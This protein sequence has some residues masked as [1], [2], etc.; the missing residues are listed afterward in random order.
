MRRGTTDF[1][2][3]ER[4][5]HRRRA[6]QPCRRRGAFDQRRGPSCACR[7]PFGGRRGPSCRKPPSVTRTCSC[8]CQFGNRRKFGLY[9]RGNRCQMVLEQR[10]PR[11]FFR[12]PLYAR[13][14]WIV[15][16]TARHGDDDAM[17]GASLTV[18]RGQPWEPG[19]RPQRRPIWPQVV[20]GCT[21]PADTSAHVIEPVPAGP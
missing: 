16:S 15:R 13:R 17:V 21:E 14:T 1:H 7:G 11:S 5:G 2:H 4:V 18:V 20:G 19:S 6:R 3:R 8:G 10:A 9:D 12:V